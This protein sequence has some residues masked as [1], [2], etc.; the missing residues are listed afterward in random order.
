MKVWGLDGLSYSW[1]LAGHGLR[2]SEDRPRSS[3]HLRAR[4]LLA[5]LY[6]LEVRLEEVPLPG[7]G[8]LLADFVL[9]GCRL[10]V[11]VQGQQHYGFNEYFHKNA[12]GFYFSQ[13]RDRRKSVFCELNSL[14]HV[15]L[16]YHESDAQ[17][18][19]RINHRGGKAPEGDR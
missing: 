13:A 14:F 3:Y 5:N 1:K 19:R 16:P 11:E 4:A 7:T 2:P 9:P 15:E 6:P 8:G 12:L 17:W 10:V 18:A